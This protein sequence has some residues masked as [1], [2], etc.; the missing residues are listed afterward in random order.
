VYVKFQ[1]RLPSHPGLGVDVTT[2]VN[3]SPQLL[4]TTG[5]VGRTSVWSGQATVADP[6]GVLIENGSRSTV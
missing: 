5:G 3:T 6:F 1:F 4:V 2:G